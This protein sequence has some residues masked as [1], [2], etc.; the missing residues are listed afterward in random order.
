M[1]HEIENIAYEKSSLLSNNYSS[2]LLLQKYEK[3][4]VIIRTVLLELIFS[5]L[6]GFCLFF[7]F[8]LSLFLLPEHILCEK[9]ILVMKIFEFKILIFSYVLKSPEFIYA[10]FT[11]AYV[12]MRA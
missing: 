11:A 10:T 7:F 5:L 1:L 2:P 3:C 8:R 6:H 4:I 9:S 12:R